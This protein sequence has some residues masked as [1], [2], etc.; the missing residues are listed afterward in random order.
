[1]FKRMCLN[2]WSYNPRA[3]LQKLSDNDSYI[4]I[5]ASWLVYHLEACLGEGAYE[6]SEVLT[7]RDTFCLQLP[8]FSCET[9][10][11]TIILRCNINTERFISLNY[12]F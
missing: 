12:L 5:E 11:A 2:R 9:N 3:C 6:Q 1:M 4:R 8:R 7:F 10:T